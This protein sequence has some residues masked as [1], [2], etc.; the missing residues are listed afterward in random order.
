M[1][2]SKQNIFFQRISW[3]FFEVPKE[4]LRIWRNFLLFNLNY[5]SIPLLLRTFFS[6]W[7]RYREFH[8]KGFSIGRYVEVFFSNLIFCLLGA[9]MRSFLI[10]IGILVEIFLILAGLFVFLGWFILPI[11]L[12]LGLILGLRT[13]FS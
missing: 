4:I 13:L 5:F 9:I 10:I 8:G 6:P 1:N 7:R 12:A 11:I 2:G 3:H